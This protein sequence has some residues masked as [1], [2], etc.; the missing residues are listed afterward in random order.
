[1]TEYQHPSR[2][3]DQQRRAANASVFDRLARAHDKL[4]ARGEDTTTQ[5]T[6]AQQA[7]DAAQRIRTGH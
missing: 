6:R 3:T 1:M 5:Q 4:A 2:M 7:R